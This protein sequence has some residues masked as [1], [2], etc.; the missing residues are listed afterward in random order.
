MFLSTC[1]SCFLA[2]QSRQIHLIH[3]T[4]TAFTPQPVLKITPSALHDSFSTN[5]STKKHTVKLLPKCSS[6]SVLPA[7]QP[8]A[9]TTGSTTNDKS[10]SPREAYPIAHPPTIRATRRRSLTA[11]RV[12]NARRSDVSRGRCAGK[13]AAR[14]GWIVEVAAVGVEV[15]LLHPR[16]LSIL[17]RCSLSHKCTR[18]RCTGQCSMR[19]GTWM[20]GIHATEGQQRTSHRRMRSWRGLRGVRRGS[21]RGRLCRGNQGIPTTYTK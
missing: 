13:S 7:R 19:A 1:S 5:S 3:Q 10:P 11:R 18:P 15:S 20:Q 6:Y 17:H 16:S 8:T 4:K 12:T 14:G 2:A 21:C 9:I